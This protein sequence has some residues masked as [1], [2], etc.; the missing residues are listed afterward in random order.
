MRQHLIS[1]RLIENELDRFSPSY[2]RSVVFG[3][4]ALAMVEVMLLETVVDE[5]IRNPRR[6]RRRP[7]LHLYDLPPTTEYF[8]SPEGAP[9]QPAMMVKMVPYREL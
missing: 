2:F 9:P 4:E 7:H 1:Q 3:I 6:R 5:L 8:L